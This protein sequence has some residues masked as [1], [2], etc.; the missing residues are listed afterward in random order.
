MFWV[1]SQLNCFQ[2]IAESELQLIAK[3]QYNN[4]ECI[5]PVFQNH[6][7]LV[8]YG[9]FIMWIFRNYLLGCDALHSGKYVHCF[10]GTCLFSLQARRRWH[11]GEVPVLQRNI[12]NFFSFRVGKGLI[13][14]CRFFQNVST[15]QPDSRLSIILSLQL[16]S[17]IYW[18][19]FF[20]V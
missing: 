6:Y 2:P 15:Y 8:S 12:T 13:L 11:A 3:S 17:D 18:C 10:S 7:T 16:L 4:M 9:I 14:Y 1:I 19:S 20:S 5:L